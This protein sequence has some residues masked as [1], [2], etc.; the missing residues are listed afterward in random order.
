[1]RLLGWHSAGQPVFTT[2][3][4]GPPP[5]LRSLAVGERAYWNGG[6]WVLGKVRWYRRFWWWLRWKVAE[7]GP[8]R[9]SR[10]IE[11]VNERSRTIT[12]R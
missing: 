9:F 2:L 7:D 11:A 5:S 3:D 6:C 12:F 4:L 10:T 8:R 1:M